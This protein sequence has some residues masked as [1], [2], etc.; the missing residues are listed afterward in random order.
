MD[1]PCQPEQLLVR[2]NYRQLAGRRSWRAPLF[3]PECGTRNPDEMRFCGMCGERLPDRTERKAG[4]RPAASGIVPP[5]TRAL[6]RPEDSAHGEKWVEA[7]ASSSNPAD[8][9]NPSRAL[10]D[11]LAARPRKRYENEER[12]G[13]RGSGSPSSGFST[14]SS[15]STSPSFLGLG[16]ADYEPPQREISWRFW[17]LMLV[18]LGIVALFGL[19]WRANRLRAEQAKPAP[20][21]VAQPAEQGS[22]SDDLKGSDAQPKSDPAQPASTADPQQNKTTND[23]KTTKDKTAEPP[24]TEENKG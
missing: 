3:C 10:V 24:P 4:N 1:F 22:P 9:S 19:Q 23:I 21:G 13:R 15:S 11:S 7:P 16:N 20:S 14:P 12:R 5:A 2:S 18:L 6:D 8:A 17:A